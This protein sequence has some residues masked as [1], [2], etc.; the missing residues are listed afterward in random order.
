MRLADA[1]RGMS[2]RSLRAYREA[3]GLPGA[4]P[5]E[6]AARLCAPE[7]VRD[8]TGA[9]EPAALLALRLLWY[10]GGASVPPWAF[11]L[12]FA[13]LGVGVGA[14]RAVGDLVTAAL[15][16]PPLAA[17]GQY[18][19]PD[20]IRPALRGIAQADWLPESGCLPEPGTLGDG[21]WAEPAAVVAD[22]ARLLGAARDGVRLRQ[23][24]AVPYQADQRRLRDALDRASQPSLP[25][26]DDGQPAWPG[27]EPEL[28]PLFAAAA[29]LGLIE[30]QPGSW[31]VAARA[32]RW[33]ALPPERQWQGLLA[34]WAELAASAVPGAP[35]LSGE[36][37]ALILR[38]QWCLPERLAEWL[39]RFA[40]SGAPALPAQVRNAVVRPGVALGALEWVQTPAGVAVRVR[41][42]AA[43]ALAGDPA[44]L[45]MRDAPLV[46][47]TFEVVAGP[48][49]APFLWWL[50]E[51][52]A[53]REALD[54]FAT[55]RLTRRSVLGGARRGGRAAELLAALEASPGGIPQNVAYSVQ[56]WSAGVAR[57]W[58]E[59]A[60]LLRCPDA[61]AAARAEATGA[62]RECE[63][64]G[65]T[66]WLIPAARIGDVWRP[67]LEAGF[68]IA[69]DPGELRERVRAR[70][71]RGGRPPAPAPALPWPAAP[72]AVPWPGEP[73]DQRAAK[74][75]AQ[76]T[77]NSGSPA[78]ISP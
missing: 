2:D 71:E 60:I 42:A 33:V 29:A 12:A 7:R 41:P 44:P 65:P 5:A 63:P 37:L 31:Q 38:G 18:A 68:E 21:A 62:L 77:A 4:E 24:E 27:Y 75:S 11:H 1:L 25:V 70:P 66:A 14:E 67:L 54:R 26:A 10:G 6:V 74:A 59:A 48:G 34:V 36:V 57:L 13:A 28:G 50:L 32:E 39:A 55:Y 30:A 46:Q 15:V 43:A 20:E 8:A 64:L 23:G 69:G 17:G 72:A 78:A 49:V 22:C 45:P 52:W 58:A 19:L 73:G 47:G 3:A 76:P 53:E 40:R 61:A 9:L 16:L 56:E 51:S 35:A